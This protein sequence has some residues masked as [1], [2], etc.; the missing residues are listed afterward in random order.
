MTENTTGH[1]LDWDDEIEAEGG[2]WT[3]LPEGDYNFRVKSFER[4]HHAGAGKIPACSKAI[5]HLEIDAPEGS[6]QID[7]NLF[8]YS[9]ME[10]KLSEFFRSIGQKQHGERVRMNWSAVSGS[11]GQCKLGVHTFTKKDGTEGKSNEIVRFYDPG[12]ADNTV[13]NPVLATAQ[14]ATTTWNPGAF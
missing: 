10:W 7:C 5:V 12:E 1:A 8:L 2:Q 14:Q 3:L 11:T 4:A 9:T 6:A 13:R